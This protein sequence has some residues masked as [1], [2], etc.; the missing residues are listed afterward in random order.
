[1]KQRRKLFSESPEEKSSRRVA[2]GTLGGIATATGAGIG[3]LT[4]ENKKSKLGKTKSL[5]ENSIKKDSEVINKAAEELT[6][7]PKNKSIGKKINSYLKSKST[8]EKSLKTLEK[9][10]KKV[11]P[12]KRALLGAGL[13]A[14]ATLGANEVVKRI[15]N[16]E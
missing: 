15:N 4:G 16:K 3:Y 12:K 2:I 9:K 14:V 1:M 8:K 6:K 11:S 13:G 10:L 5:L 7:N